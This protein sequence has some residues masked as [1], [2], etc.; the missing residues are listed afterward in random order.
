MSLV[1]HLST[2][3][4][5][6]LLIL[7]IR[8]TLSPSYFI[9]ATVA[10]IIFA[11]VSYVIVIVE[12]MTSETFKYA[13]HALSYDEA[14][15]YMTFVSTTWPTIRLVA[16]CSHQEIVKNKTKKIVTH[17]EESLFR[18]SR[19]MDRTEEIHEDVLEEGSIIRVSQ[20]CT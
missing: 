20:N 15:S 14:L 19:M 10:I 7:L 8:S 5:L 6:S 4:F 17:R 3:F 16:E 12:G 11:V 2:I 18:F 9:S 1:A 13:R